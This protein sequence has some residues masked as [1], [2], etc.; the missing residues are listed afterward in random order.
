MSPKLFLKEQY[1]N[2]QSAVWKRK[3]HQLIH[4][5]DVHSSSPTDCKLPGTTKI[6][7]KLLWEGTKINRKTFRYDRDLFQENDLF[8]PVTLYKCRRKSKVTEKLEKEEF[9]KTSFQ[10][11]RGLI[12]VLENLQP[13][14]PT[15]I[16]LMMVFASQT[17]QQIK[18]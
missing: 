3:I 1:E 17:Q 18:K 11:L 2:L 8:A 15:C 9:Q 13:K 7:M 5:N 4:N 6:I 16:Q 10:P 12:L 14:P